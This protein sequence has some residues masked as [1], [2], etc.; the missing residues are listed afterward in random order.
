MTDQVYR[1]RYDSDEPRD[2]L[3]VDEALLLAAEAGEIGPTLRTW[4]FSKPVVVLGRSSKVDVEVNRSFCQSNRIPILRRC[5]GGASVVGGPGCLMYSVV[6]DFAKS[7]DL[8]KI[9]GAHQYVMHRVLS[10][11]QRQLPNARLQG[12]CDLTIDNRKVSGN[13]LR[14]TR[15]HVLYHGTILHDFDLSLISRCLDHAPRQP[16]YRS[17]REHRDFV[18]QA[19]LVPARFCEDLAAEFSAKDWVET[20]HLASQIARLRQERYDQD[21]WHFRH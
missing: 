18:G 1:V 12:I 17:E 8:R 5:T 9:D 7:G 14:L 21:Q 4:S 15:T 6:L 19:N 16:E 13:S 20:G 2:Q 3:A 11:V 10:A